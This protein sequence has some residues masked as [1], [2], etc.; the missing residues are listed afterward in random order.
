MP[1]L[2]YFIRHSRFIF[3]TEEENP[4]LAIWV[5]SAGGMKDMLSTMLR[6]PFFMGRDKKMHKMPE[7]IEL[8]FLE[9]IPRVFQG[10]EPEIH[11]VKSREELPEY[12]WEEHILMSNTKKPELDKGDVAHRAVKGL[13]TAVPILGG[14]GAEFFDLIIAPPL[15][16]RRD[17]WIESIALRLD[18]LEKR[19]NSFYIENLSQNQIFIT[20]I[21]NATQSAI[22]NHQ[23]EKL[24][25]LRSAVLNS[26]ISNTPEED[27]QI[28]FVNYIDELTVWHIKIL[29]FLNNPNSWKGDITP[30]MDQIN[31]KFYATFNLRKIL[32]NNFP[33][34]KDEY[35]FYGQVIK[36]L[37][38]R[39]LIRTESMKFTNNA[40][41]KLR[42][43]CV[44]QMGK[45]FIEYIIPPLN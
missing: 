36:D 16:K 25:I 42:M 29:K 45:K 6:G 43:N 24:D 17:E 33:Q 11:K 44:T 34:L 32:L 14:L 3:D 40:H 22:K 18:E 2:Y 37:N 35:E 20:I 21:M 31:G 19:E 9:F 4:E 8:F 38:T 13:I 7:E 30:E 26:A 12:N 15:E 39:G 1:I 28:M 41:T 27:L 5:D 23:K 10:G